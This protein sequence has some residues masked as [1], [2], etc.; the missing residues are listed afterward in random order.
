MVKWKLEKSGF[1]LQMHISISI[2]QRCKQWETKKLWK[3]QGAT[4]TESLDVSSLSK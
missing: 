1:T 4:E 2:F 3:K